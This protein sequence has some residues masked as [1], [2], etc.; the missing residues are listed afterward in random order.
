VSV[1]YYLQCA[2]QWDGRKSWVGHVETPTA[3]RSM[4]SIRSLVLLR[5]SWQDTKVRKIDPQLLS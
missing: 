3:K 5:L 1:H 4:N 2:N